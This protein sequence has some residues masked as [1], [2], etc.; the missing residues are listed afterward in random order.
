MIYCMKDHKVMKKEFVF[1]K[2]E[3]FWEDMTQDFKDQI[4]VLVQEINAVRAF[5]QL[6]PFHIISPLPSQFLA[7]P[8][9]M[10]SS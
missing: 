6:S 10:P 8:I 4:V 7:L 5:S 2:K 3:Q 1:S 9:L